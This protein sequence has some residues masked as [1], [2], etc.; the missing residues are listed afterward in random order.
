VK[1][2]RCV[3]ALATVVTSTH[4]ALAQSQVGA[5]PIADSSTARFL[6]TARAATERYRDQA[7]AITDGYRRVG[8]DL[9]SM[10]EHW[11]SIGRVV[12]NELAG[13]RPSVLMYVPNGESALLV[14]VAYTA[15]LGPGAPYPSF[16]PGASAPWHEHNGSVDEEALPMLHV[17][18][19]APSDTAAVRARL[20]ILHVWLW[21]EN[22]AGLWTADNW[23]LPFVRAGLR[24]PASP[25]ASARALA[26]AMGS[27]EYYV[28]V[29]TAI[30]HLGPQQREVAR[31]LLHV[32][33]DSARAVGG[34]LP[35]L[36]RVW[37]DLWLRLDGQLSPATMARLTP[38]R[39]AW[40]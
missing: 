15:I 10:G 40:R 29:M 1:V 4:I 2:V 22:P 27:A 13:D 23:A 33:A 37:N 11:V 35:G 20:A 21:Q 6:V 12:S 32:A 18:H 16:P 8:P 5:P 17:G 36:R 26:L 34:D 28:G 24:P 38:L 9:P 30:A 14:G 39:D 31:T 7:L 19:S 25:D 3:V